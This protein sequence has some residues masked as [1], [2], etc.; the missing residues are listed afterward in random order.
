MVD[1]VVNESMYSTTSR[2]RSGIQSTQSEFKL[3]RFNNGKRGQAG[4]LVG[5]K[6][7]MADVVDIPGDAD[8]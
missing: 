2:S 3:I 5:D 6:N 4:E 7:T 8:Y 1:K